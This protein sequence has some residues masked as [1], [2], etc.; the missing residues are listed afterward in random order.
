VNV[1]Y[2]LGLVHALGKDALV[3]KQPGTALP[4]DFGGAHYVEYD[5]ANLAAGRALLE[6]QLRQ[7]VVTSCAPSVEALER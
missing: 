2:E 4:A 3:L 5:C 1:F 6:T 7:W